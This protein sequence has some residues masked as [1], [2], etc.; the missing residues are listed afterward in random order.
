E[1]NLSETAFAVPRPD[2]T[3]DLRWFT[4]TAEVGFCGHATV[5]TAHT[6]WER[7][8]HP[9]DR[10]LVFHTLAGELGVARDGDELVLD[11]PSTPATEI[12]TPDGLVDVVG[13]EPVFVG[14]TDV[15]EPLVG[16][17]F[18]V[19]PDE[20]AVVDLDVD[21]EAVAA[22]PHGGLIVTAE[23][24]GHA[25][26]CVSRYFTPRYGVDEDPVTGSA[27]CTIGTYWTEQLGRTGIRARQAS[28]RGGDLNVTV[29][30][31]RA[32]VAGHAVTVMA[33]ELYH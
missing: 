19:L 32:H 15:D 13:A 6:L 11:G 27:H 12:P 2:S 26:D 4:P 9:V 16:N 24:D 21:I 29:T 17:L 25:Y 23:A 18:V 22:L 7:T 14:T 3:W 30:G 28:T 5:A 1:F 10:D 8:L 20:A 31:D 33:G